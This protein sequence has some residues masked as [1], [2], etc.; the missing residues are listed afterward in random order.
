MSDWHCLGNHRYRAQDELLY[1]EPHGGLSLSQAEAWSV[2]VAS[3]F[4][5]EAHGYL[6]VDARDLKPANSQVRRVLLALLRDTEP[7]PRVLVFGA[8]LLMRAV[9][10]LILA[11][12][13]QLYRIEVDFTHYA[14]EA[15]A[16][17]KIDLMRRSRKPSPPSE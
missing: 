14:T 17:A 1:F 4:Q 8:N 10:R 15:E 7:R 6:L 12:A 16:M 11:A 5:R 9:S 2:V 3:H 13:W